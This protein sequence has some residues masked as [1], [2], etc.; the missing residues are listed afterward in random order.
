MARTKNAKT[1][2]E[3]KLKE[4]AGDY[5]RLGKFISTITNNSEDEIEETAYYD[6]DGTVTST[7]KGTKE[8]FEF[9]GV[10][11]PEDPGQK[12]I[13]G[14]KDKDGDGRV[15]LLKVTDPEGNIEDGPATVTNIVTRGGEASDYAPFTCTITRNEKP[16]RSKAPPGA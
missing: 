7:V 5:V 2:Y 14:L 8:S 3:V 12:L 11:D 15:I 10:Y 1:K 13:D 16:Q 6:G 9:S 4:G